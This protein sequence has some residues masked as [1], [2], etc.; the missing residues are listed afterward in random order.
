MQYIFTYI[1]SKDVE[2]N[3]TLYETTTFKIRLSQ[4][5][6]LKLAAQRQNQTPTGGILHS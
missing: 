4:D 2:I 3:H 5:R 6:I 1:F